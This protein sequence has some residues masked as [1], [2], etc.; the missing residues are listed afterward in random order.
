MPLIGA[1]ADD[2]TGATTSGILLARSGAKTAVFFHEQAV[3]PE[4]AKKLDAILISS[5]SR[6]LRT[7]TAYE[8]VSSI[9]T[10]L[11]NLGVKYFSKRIDTTLRG[12]LGSEIDAMVDTIGGNLIS[13]VVPT[14][15]QS[16]RIVVG[17]FSIIDG[18]ILTRTPASED[19]LTPV[20]ESYIP[21][22]LS[23]QTHRKIKSIKLD[24]VMK[25]PEAVATAMSSARRQGG[26]ILIVDAISLEDVDVI[27]KACVRLEWEVLAVDPGAFTTRLA[28]CRGLVDEEK[29]NIP[30]G[31]VNNKTALLIA[32]SATV[33]T[34]KQ[35]DLLCAEPGNI[36]ISIAPVPLIEGGAKAAIAR[37]QAVEHALILL[38]GNTKPRAILLE[39]ALHDEPLNLQEED[40]QRGLPSGGSSERIN[41]NL[42]AI[43]EEILSKAGQEKIAGLYVTGG[44]TMLSVCGHLGVHCIELFDYVT[45]QTDIGRLVGNYD[46]LPIIC[47]GGL[48]GY[49]RIGLDIVDRLFREA[50]RNERY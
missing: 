22:L 48:T 41:E 40:A 23:G 20:S 32:G 11:Q 44:D 31:S 30:E 34:R 49:D 46:G 8:K 15:P 39:T 36:R 9:T 37:S 2:L 42:G 10:L 26:Q 28:F 17:G 43:T 19:V 50:L 47:K 25:G 12:N 21:R 7:K 29:S 27:A 4:Y 24:I 1:V 13:V 6:S 38:S 33:T 3:D 5:N 18:Q 14:M 16:R 35:M 45:A